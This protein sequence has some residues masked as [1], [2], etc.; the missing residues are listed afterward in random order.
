MVLWGIRN[1][2]TKKR[3]SHNRGRC[4]AE[5]RAEEEGDCDVKD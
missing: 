4:R 3:K 5:R 2:I 1:Y